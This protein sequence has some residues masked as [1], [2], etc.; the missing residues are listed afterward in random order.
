[1]GSRLIL[2]ELVPCEVGRDGWLVAV[3]G[4]RVELANLDCMPLPRC[5]VGLPKAEAVARMARLL[6][7]D[8]NVAP[9]VTVLSDPRAA[10][11]A[12]LSELMITC[13]DRQPARMMAAGV[14]ARF[15]RVHMD[16]AGGAAFTESRAVSAGGEVR[17]ALPGSSGG[18]VGCMNDGQDWPT[19][20]RDMNESAEGQRDERLRNDPH[21]ERPGS[22]GAVLS[23]VLGTGMLLFWR[24]LQG[25]LRRSVWLHLDANGDRPEWQDWTRLAGAGECRVCTVDDVRGLGEWEADGG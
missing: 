8:A 19:A 16:L 17:L 7:P 6:D 13:V 22:C 15:C 1:M 10:E 9:L 24:L 4:D 14:A 25:R 5:A 11:A 21:G 3:D 12:A 20:V 18:C 23:S 2:Q